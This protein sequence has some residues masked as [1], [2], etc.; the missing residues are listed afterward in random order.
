MLEELKGNLAQ[1]QNLM[2]QQANK[3]RREMEL[4]EGDSV[5]LKIQPYKLQSLAKRINQKLSPRFYGPFQILEKIGPVAYKL[6]LPENSRIHPVFH[7]SLLKKA[8]APT[9]VCQD[10]PKCLNEELE[11]Q[12]IPEEVVESRR[13]QEG[14]E[15]VLIHWKGLPKFEDTW[16]D[17]QVMKDL[18]PEFHLED[19]VNFQ[20]GSIDRMTAQPPIKYFNKVYQRKRGRAV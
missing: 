14:K 2:Q 11:L 6:K 8:L 12:V 18:F 5:Y 3:H 4:T 10:L 20:G 9:T 19:K 17:A 15:E 13:N 1:A 16:E 7:V